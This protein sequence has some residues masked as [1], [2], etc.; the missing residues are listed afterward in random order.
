MP[1]NKCTDLMR[2]EKTLILQTSKNSH[3]FAV[4]DEDGYVSLFDSRR[5]LPSFACHQENA[6]LSSCL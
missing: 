5:K 6:G 2:E 3:I 1:A 4:S